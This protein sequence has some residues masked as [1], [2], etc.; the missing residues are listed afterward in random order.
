M[1]RIILLFL[2]LITLSLYPIQSLAQNTQQHQLRFSVFYVHPEEFYQGKTLIVQFEIEYIGDMNFTG[3]VTLKTKTQEGREYTDK[4]FQITNLVSNEVYTNVTSYTTDFAG[5]I[6]T[7]LR[8]DSYIGEIISFYEGETLVNEGSRVEH[9]ISI[10][11]K[12]YDTY[13]REKELETS[14]RNLETNQI[15]VIVGVITA[16]IASLGVYLTYKYRKNKDKS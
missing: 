8:I 9:E 13:L 12:S 16:L 6:Y 3:E 7:T 5:R 4:E 1:K 11:V 2:L 14:K 15:R 10:F